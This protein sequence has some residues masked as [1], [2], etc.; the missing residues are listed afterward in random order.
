MTFLYPDLSTAITGQF[1]E[2]RLTRGHAARVRGVAWTRGLP[3]PVTSYVSGTRDIYSY[4]PSGSLC[5]S[6]SPLLRDLYETRLVYVTQSQVR[7]REQFYIKTTFIDQ[8]TFSLWWK[9]SFAN[10]S[11]G[12]SDHAGEGLFA[13]TDIPRGSLVALFNGVRQHTVPGQLDTRAWSDYRWAHS[14]RCRWLK[15][16]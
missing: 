15:L 9:H 14:F 2:G 3:S 10:C 5:I 7:H 6:K 12:V 1:R 4:Q 8:Q 13:K 11:P 16:S